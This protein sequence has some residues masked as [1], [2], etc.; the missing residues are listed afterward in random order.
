[1]TVFI[2]V[3]AKCSLKHVF[4]PLHCRPT[5]ASSFNKT[6]IDDSPLLDDL[7]QAKLREHLP[8]QAIPNQSTNE[9]DVNNDSYVDDSDTDHMFLPEKCEL[10]RCKQD[11]FAAC[12]ECLILLCYNH[13]L[14]DPELCSQ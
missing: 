10:K 4:V 13:F 12:T 5:M 7:P 11:V 2:A 1:M 9:K 3:H 8:E 6:I 14:E